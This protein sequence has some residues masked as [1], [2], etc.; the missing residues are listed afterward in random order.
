MAQ[1]VTGQHG[2]S[3]FFLP[4]ELPH[5]PP[6]WDRGSVRTQ[7]LPMK[8]ATCYTALS[9]GRMLD[10]VPGGHLMGHPFSPLP[11][12]L[13]GLLKSLIQPCCRWKCPPGNS[14]FW[15]GSEQSFIGSS[16]LPLLMRKTMSFIEVSLLNHQEW[17]RVLPLVMHLLT[18]LKE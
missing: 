18:W 1:T 13:S 15:C 12:R 16:Q 14:L 8:Y 11:I 10:V 4:F 2:R 17:N 3:P 6:T 7:L 5:S 9:S